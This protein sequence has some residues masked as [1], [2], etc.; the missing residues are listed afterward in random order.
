LKAESTL[1]IISQHFSIK[2][3]STNRSHSRKILC[4]YLSL[5]PYVKLSVISMGD[6]LWDVANSQRHS[7]YFRPAT[8][9]SPTFNVSV[10]PPVLTQLKARLKRSIAA[11]NILN[12]AVTDLKNAYDRKQRNMDRFTELWGTEEFIPNSH[13]PPSLSNDLMQHF[14]MLSKEVEDQQM[15]LSELWVTPEDERGLL[16]VLMGME[17]PTQERDY[18][19][20]DVLKDA[21]EQV[22]AETQAN[23]SLQYTNIVGVARCTEYPPLLDSWLKIILRVTF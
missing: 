9:L 23:L 21:R 11:E 17:H 19:I 20:L 14:Y 13:K 12:S 22:K 5:K 7:T 18:I 4:H 10:C 2:S 6:N 3:S 1:F 16:P 15:E 8:C